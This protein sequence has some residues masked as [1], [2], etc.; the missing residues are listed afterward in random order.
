M[1][2]QEGHPVWSTSIDD[3]TLSAGGDLNIDADSINMESQ[4]TLTMDANGGDM[5][6]QANGGNVLI[7]ASGTTSVAGSTVN[8]AGDAVGNLTA[9]FLNIT[10]DATLDLDG[11]NVTVDSTGTLSLGSD[12]TININAAAPLTLQSDTL[13]NRIAPLIL[14][15]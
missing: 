4:T 14:P 8:L 2:K 1:A 13:I 15:P 7:D 3:L 10:A 11:L 5:S 9:P 6:L 12:A